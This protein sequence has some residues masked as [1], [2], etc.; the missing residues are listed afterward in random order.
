MLLPLRFRYRLFSGFARTEQTEHVAVCGVTL[1]LLF[2][3]GS[4]GSN[5]RVHRDNC[6]RCRR[7]YTIVA[8]ALLLLCGGAVAQTS[9]GSIGGTI[10]DESDAVVA[11]ATI[12]A[13]NQETGELRSTTSGELGQ[14]RMDA[15]EP[16]RYSV[17]IARADF[18]P[19]VLDQVVVDASVVTSVNAKLRAG[20]N[21]L[22][23]V[24]EASG[25]EVQTETGELSQTIG[26]SETHDLPVFSLN[27]YALA[28]TLPGCSQVTDGSF[29]FTNGVAYSCNGTRPRSN[30]F[31]LEGQ[32]NNDA[33][34][35]GQ[36]LQ[37]QN[38]DSVQEV[39]FL[40]N[41]AYAEFG[42]GGGAIANLIYRS[43]TNNF[44]GE[45]WDRLS[46]SSLD[47]NDHANA[48]AGIPKNK[49][50][51]NFF[52]FNVGGPLKKD[53]LFF[54]A[55]YQ[56]DNFRSSENGGTLILPTAAGFAVLQKYA[57]NPRIAAMLAAYDSLRGDP[58]R[59]VEPI[60]LGLDPVT[61]QDRGSV[62]LG[63]FNRTGVP[64]Q[65]NSPEFD[66]KGDYLIGR[67][68]V[69]TL[70]Y[71]RTSFN[72]PFDFFHFANNLPGFDSDQNGVWQNAGITYTHIFTPNLLNEV[73]VSY[74]RMGLSF[75]P[76]PDNVPADRMPT[77]VIDGIQGWGA[78]QLIP[79]GRFHDTYQ[80]Q[81]AVSWSK[82]R[83]FFKFGFD[84]ADVRVR[85]EI[86]FNFFGSI[87]Y[88]P[89]GGYQALANYLDDF[90]GGTAS[91][92]QT[93]GS[94][95][96]HTSVPSQNYFFQCSWRA[97]PNLVLDFGLRYEYNGS[98]ANQLAFPAIEYSNLS[99]FP[100]VVKQRGDKEDFGPRFGFAY[101]P[102]F[103]RQ[104]LG[105]G[106]TVVRG[107]FGVFYDNQFIN[108]MD[109][110]Q[111][112]SPNSV[113]SAINVS[114]RTRGQANWSS[115]FSLLPTTPNAKATE[116]SQVAHL[117]QWHL[118]T[119]RE[120][121]GKS[122]LD[123][124]YVGTRGEHLFAATFANPFLPSGRRL[125]P[126]RGTI[127]V[128]DNSG[129]S[130]YHALQVQ[131]NR[132]YSHGFLLRASY[133]F[134]K[135]IDDSSE[136]FTPSASLNGAPSTWSS[137]PVVQFPSPRGATDR[138][139][140]AFD[141]RQR[142][143][144]TYIYDIPKFAP[145]GA[146]ASGLGHLL[147]GWQISG[148]TWFQ[149]GTP[150]NVTTGFDSNNDGV[151]NDGPSLGDPHAPLA[152]YAF[153]ANPWFS[154]TLP[155]NLLCDGPTLWFTN[156][157]TFVSRSQV[158]W[159]VPANGQ[160]NVGRNSLVGPWYTT[161]AF[162]LTRN[163]LV[164]EGQTLQI[165]GELFNPFNQTHRDGDGYWP[166]M[167]LVSGVVPT[168]SGASSTFADF[169]T[170]LHGGRTVRMLLKYSL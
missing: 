103:W 146:M 147:N 117:L 82:G 130:I 135:M 69:L 167:Q 101:T 85:D 40:L 143:A 145:H 122:T 81:D 21:A 59:P 132:R 125:I 31:L 24:V 115:F 134:S 78:S 124:G 151:N 98:P 73:R 113:A 43:G 158:H 76:R 87:S 23:V 109:N 106:K 97:R 60:P 62:A 139:L 166:N 110:T 35:H 52:G 105:D 168:G 137:V 136:V 44:H 1:F 46:N 12:T 54:F 41:S 30:N 160:G 120:L 48:L 20:G 156:Q 155:S 15:V 80:V 37:P 45:V 19:L 50:R 169:S 66:A 100:C 18:A 149:S 9:K 144:F 119:E 58:N 157:C 65:Y 108:I 39:A 42:H 56:W 16:G 34:I 4:T 67:N 154:S 152:S 22:S 74:G 29:S 71:I 92:S 96:V 112:S 129:D 7:L 111:A 26:P 25:A 118:D 114:G 6:V 148:T 126:T 36:G 3:L 55:S 13:T 153:T 165:R 8:A 131:V 90:S 33:G 84:I 11:G 32:D 17:A 14:Y 2:A 28:N 70:R 89:G 121:P 27:P 72:T 49:Y 51:E 140:S 170:S 61:G 57:S 86:P 163:V 123:L 95:I 161:W 68:D 116:Q 138:S 159:I 141:H 133:T 150:Y 94:P 91:V 63:L 142:W 93:F 38:V 164:H 162:S 99:C 107:G 79:Q 83:H 102:S 77:I 53:K 104:F 88:R 64:V 127:G 5:Y 128:R 75:L 47:A 10:T